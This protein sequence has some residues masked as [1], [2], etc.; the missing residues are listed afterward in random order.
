[1]LYLTFERNTTKDVLPIVIAFPQLPYVTTKF[2]DPAEKVIVNRRLYFAYPCKNIASF[3]E[4]FKEFKYTIFNHYYAF[5]GRFFMDFRFDNFHV[6][7]DDVTS[8]ANQM[9]PAI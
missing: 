2:I 4:G 7:Q 1:M 8:E 3:T 9:N 5:P 6:K